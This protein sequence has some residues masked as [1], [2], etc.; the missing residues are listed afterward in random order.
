VEPFE[1]SS[2]RQSSENGYIKPG[3]TCVV[4]NKETFLTFLDELDAARGA[5]EML[6]K[7]ASDQ[8]E[9]TAN[10]R[11]ALAGLKYRPSGHESAATLLKHIEAT[12]KL[13]EA[14]IERQPRWNYVGEALSHPTVQ[15]ARAK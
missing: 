15:A 13:I 3:Q 11:D 4:V 6:V 2:S 5:V 14:A 10:D 12:N 7:A 9:V 1:K 8:L